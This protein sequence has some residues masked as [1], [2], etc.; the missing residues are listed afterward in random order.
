VAD[1]RRLTQILALSTLFLGTAVPGAAATN[2]ARASASP[3]GVLTTAP[4]IKHVIVI[5]EENHSYS[6]TVGHMPYLD[7]LAAQCGLATNYHSTTHNSLPNY[8]AMT[9]GLPMA[10]L[11]PFVGDCSPTT[12]GTTAGSIFAQT[13]AKSYQESMPSNCDWN[14]SGEYAPKH[15]PYVYYKVKDSCS[16]RDVSLTSLVPDFGKEATAP[17]FA[18]VT[19]NLCNDMHDCSVG[20]GDAWLKALVPKLI[21]TPVYQ[22]HD[23]AILITTDEGE[24]ASAGENCAANVGDQSCHV[25]LVVVAPSVKPGTRAAG[26]FNHYSLL[27]ASEDLLGLS[28]LGQAASAPS[29]IPS[30]NL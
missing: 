15:N 19:P 16:T 1:M 21:A 27:R 14:G 11:A 12:C 5:M 24:P 17:S 22:S 9:S 25:E 23:T 6:A 20:T 8:L 4:T 29:L 3:C 7:G 2:H 26:S 18:F 13:F 28:R 30:F 10:S